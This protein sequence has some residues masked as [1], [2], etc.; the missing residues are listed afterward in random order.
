MAFQDLLDE[1]GWMEEEEEEEEQS[2]SG[3]NSKIQEG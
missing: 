1:G 2:E 3:E